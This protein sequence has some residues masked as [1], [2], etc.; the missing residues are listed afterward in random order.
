MKKIIKRIKNGL[1]TALV[2]IGSIFST[3]LASSLVTE[4]NAINASGSYAATFDAG[5]ELVGSPYS[6]ANRLGHN[7]FDC[8]GFVDYLYHIT[9]ID[10]TPYNAR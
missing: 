5:V 6:T 10:D 4:I 2:A 8:S 3:P 7:S 9:G 1:L